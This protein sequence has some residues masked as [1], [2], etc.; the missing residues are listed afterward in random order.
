MRKNAPVPRSNRVR[1]LGA[2]TGVGVMTALFA[3]YVLSESLGAADADGSPRVAVPPVVTPAGLERR[4]G[5]RIVYVAVSGA[6]GLVDLRYQVVDAAKAAAVHVTQ[7]ELVDEGSGV[8]VDSL[9]MNHSHTGRFRAGQTY[10]LVFENPG[11]LVQRG[12]R[13]TVALGGVRVPHVHVQ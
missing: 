4:S 11:N 6:G 2:M 1:L 13:V 5:V 8:V 10:Y 12:G 3:G 9:L 7:P